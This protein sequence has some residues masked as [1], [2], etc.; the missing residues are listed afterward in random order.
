MSDYYFTQPLYP[1]PPPPAHS[2]KTCSTKNEKPGLGFSGYTVSI[3]VCLPLEGNHLL[4][5]PA[6]DTDYGYLDGYLGFR[7]ADPPSHPWHG[8]MAVCV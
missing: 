5:T 1:S 3:L 8:G 2:I 6:T 4:S 7:L